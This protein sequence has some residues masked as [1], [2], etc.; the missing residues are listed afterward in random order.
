MFDTDFFKTGTPQGRHNVSCEV[1]GKQL[2]ELV[3]DEQFAHLNDK[4][5]NRGV[6]M[7]SSE[8]SY[9]LENAE[10]LWET[11]TRLT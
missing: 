6:E 10:D 2:A 4:Y 9:S 5:V 7:P 11:S 1:S 8:L 3:I